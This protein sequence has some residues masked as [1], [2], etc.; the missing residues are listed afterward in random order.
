MMRVRIPVESGNAAIKSGRLPQLM[1]QVLGALKPEAAYF[2]A[3][4]GERTAYLF[5]D[6]KDVADIPKIAE[7]FFIELN[8]AVELLPVMNADDL[9][10]GLKQ[11]VAG[12]M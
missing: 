1:Q 7:P 5:F 12:S 2:T 9:Q 3:D 4:G 10:R 6:M 8:A 11:V